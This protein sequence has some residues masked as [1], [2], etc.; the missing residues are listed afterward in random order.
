MASCTCP[1]GGSRGRDKASNMG[2][3]GK[4][5]A[6]HCRW[7][8]SD[9]ARS[10]RAVWV[11][12]PPQNMQAWTV[13]RSW[14]RGAQPDRPRT[15]ATTC[16]R[17][18]KRPHLQDPQF[19]CSYPGLE[20]VNMCLFS[21]FLAICQRREHTVEENPLVH[22]DQQQQKTRLWV[23]RPCIHVGRS[24]DLDTRK[25]TPLTVTALQPQCHLIGSGVWKDS[26]STSRSQSSRPSQIDSFH[27]VDGAPGVMCT[28]LDW[29]FIKA[30]SN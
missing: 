3:V 20:I 19:S 10:N 1:G 22:W 24:W 16:H 29:W 18:F 2:L 4:Y 14:I 13:A 30:G 8:G 11:S 7:G 23:G 17:D 26:G 6:T 21:F 12:F 5:G 9:L 27:L 28:Q 25:G 15:G